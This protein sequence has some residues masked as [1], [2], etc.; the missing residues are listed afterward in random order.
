M[1]IKDVP[2]EVIDK[3]RAEFDRLVDDSQNLCNRISDMFANHMATT[4]ACFA[5]RMLVVVAERD[6]PK[7]WCLKKS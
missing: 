5:L 7:E 4:T 2:Q 6:F 3:A 1:D